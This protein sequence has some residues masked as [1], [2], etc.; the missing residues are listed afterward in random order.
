MNNRNIEVIGIDHG[1]SQMKTSNAPV[2]SSGIREILTEPAFYD[3]VLEYDGRYYK[4]GTVRDMVMDNKV[5]NDDYYLLTL[6]AIAKEL[7]IRGKNKADVVLAVGLPASRYGDEKQAFID[8]LSRNE[9]ITFTF[10][11][12]EY[13][14]KVIKVAVFPQCYAAVIDQIGSFGQKVVAVDIGSWTID[15]VPI[16]NKK[17]DD[18]NFNTLQEGLI[19]CMRHINKMCGRKFNEKIDEIDIQHYIRTRHSNLGEEY[20]QLMDSALT[21]FATKLYNSLREEGYSLKTTQFCFVGG[22]ACVMKNF[23]GYEQGNI[24]Y[25]LDV[26][27]NAKGFEKLAKLAMNA[28]R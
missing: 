1:W 23:G 2:F 25:N 15:I 7:K 21:E 18:S 20:K 22:G 24:K 13:E 6:A 26:K 12:E 27:A 17:P 10:E 16:I 9:N 8:Y 11:K 5:E 4:V 28:R 3:D 14:I 19:P